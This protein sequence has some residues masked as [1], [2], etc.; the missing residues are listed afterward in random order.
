MFYIIKN[1]LVN[2]KEVEFAKVCDNAMLQPNRLKKE[3]IL[4]VVFK[5]NKFIN[6][7]FE[8]EEEAK[9]ALVKMC[10]KLNKPF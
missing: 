7:I 3:T 6:I 5:D 2:T 1:V 10:E 4:K 9:E 8:T